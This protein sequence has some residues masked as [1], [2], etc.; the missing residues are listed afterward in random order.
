MSK[1]VKIVLEGLGNVWF[2][3][4]ELNLVKPTVA[5]NSDQDFDQF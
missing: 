3:Q 5:Y 4:Q 2:P 1:Y